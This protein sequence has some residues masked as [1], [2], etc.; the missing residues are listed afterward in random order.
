MPLKHATGWKMLFLLILVWPFYQIV[1]TARHE[2]S[3]A[4]MAW[5]QGATITQ[6]HVFPSWN[7]GRFYWGYTAWQGG[8]TTWL[9]SAAPYLCDLLTALVFAWVCATLIR[10]DWWLW[11]HCWAFGLWAP[12]LNSAYAY[13]LG[14]RP[15]SRN[16]VA[17]VM[18]SVPVELV[19]LWFIVTLAFYAFAVWSGARARR[20]HDPVPPPGKAP[21][22]E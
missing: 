9:V 16:D 18:R 11:F 5:W 4:A 19:H 7:P 1:G 20:M 8:H 22:L 6:V 3:H 21:R 12:L 2:L 10:R 17:T 13:F 14:I 15:T